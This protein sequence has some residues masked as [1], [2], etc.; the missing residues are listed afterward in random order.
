MIRVLNRSRHSLNSVTSYRLISTSKIP[1]SATSKSS[2]SSKSSGAPTSNSSSSKSSSK[3]SSSFSSSST[4]NVCCRDDELEEKLSDW[5]Q[6]GV[7]FTKFEIRTMPLQWYREKRRV[8]WL[9]S[10]IIEFQHCDAYFYFHGEEQALKLEWSS[11]GL[12][13]DELSSVD[14]ELN[15]QVINNVCPDNLRKFLQQLHRHKYNGFDFNCQAF[16]DDLLDFVRAQRSRD[17]AGNDIRM[18]E[19]THKVRE[20]PK[21]EDV[22]HNTGYFVTL[23]SLAALYVFYKLYS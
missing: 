19:S 23:S 7:R 13:Y 1:G 10:Q 9:K 18:Q 17:G 6:K 2:K 21:E 22:S 14:G 4:Y 11:D 16:C 8:G 5:Y 12:R 20:R 15:E 3:S